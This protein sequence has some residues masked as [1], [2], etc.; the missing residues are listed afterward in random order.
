VVTP[1]PLHGVAVAHHKSCGRS[2]LGLL[3]R[4][5]LHE[6]RGFFEKPLDCGRPGMFIQVSADLGACDRTGE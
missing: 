4:R 1:Q 3:M 5:D 2:S 6:G